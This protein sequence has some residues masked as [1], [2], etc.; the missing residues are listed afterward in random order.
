MVQGFGIMEDE[1]SGDTTHGDRPCLKFYFDN[2]EV[3]AK[4]FGAYRRSETSQ[5]LDSK[6]LALTIIPE[7]ELPHVI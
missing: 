5:Y 1:I 7:A 3:L 2:P 4:V 6:K